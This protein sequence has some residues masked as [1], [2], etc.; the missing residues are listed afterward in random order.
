M[1]KNAGAPLKQKLSG[2]NS[3]HLLHVTWTYYDAD[4]QFKYQVSAIIIVVSHGYRIL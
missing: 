1:R 3:V 4:D 2:S